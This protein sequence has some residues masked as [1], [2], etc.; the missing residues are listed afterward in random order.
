MH[1]LWLG[2]VISNDGLEHQLCFIII[3]IIIKMGHLGIKQL[4]YLREGDNY[5]PEH[6]LIPLAVVF[7][8]H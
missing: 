8:H 1:H 5:L 4:P 2:G 3:I 7:Y 6:I